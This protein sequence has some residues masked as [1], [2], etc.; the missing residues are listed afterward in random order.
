[1]PEEWPWRALTWTFQQQ[2]MSF[3]LEIDIILK[4]DYSFCC[5]HK[6]CFQSCSR[7]ISQLDSGGYVSAAYV[8]YFSQQEE[9]LNNNKE[10]RNL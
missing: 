1:M 7:T 3:A 8:T 2:D 4:A 9:K 5:S 10:N 6:A